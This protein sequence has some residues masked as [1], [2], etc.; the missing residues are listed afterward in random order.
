MEYIVFSDESYIT[1]ERFRSIAGFSFP[2]ASCAAIRENLADILRSSDVSEFKWQKLKSAKNRF[3]AQHLLDYVL[4]NIKNLKIRVDVIIWDTQ[5]ERH[6]ISKR[7]DNANFARMFFHLM[8]SLMTKREL[9]SKWHIFP[10]EKS[11]IDWR[12]IQDCLT[13]VGKWKKYFENPFFG[14]SF[15]DQFFGIVEFDQIQSKK[16]PCSQMADLFAGLAVF[17][18]NKYDKY[19]LWARQKSAQLSFIE[20]P[21][22]V[23]FTNREYY[24][25]NILQDFIEGCRR[26]RFGVSMNTNGCLKTYNP[27][28]PINF[29]HYTPQHELDKAPIKSI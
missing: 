27:K 23:K 17:S 6:R 25:F 1:A 11:E 24:R 10:D 26:N 13:N 8:K 2:F 19:N 15:S 16:E 5:D 18:K 28:N 20:E 22:D 12:N 4:E 29:W 9:N 7:D 14:D 21:V 3:C